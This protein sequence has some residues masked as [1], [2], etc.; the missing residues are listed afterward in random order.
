MGYFIIIIII[1]ALFRLKVSFLCFVFKCVGS[2]LVILV[3]NLQLATM[4]LSQQV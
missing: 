4:L 1:I 3:L 2:L